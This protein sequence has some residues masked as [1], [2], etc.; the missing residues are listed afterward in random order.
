MPLADLVPILPSQFSAPLLTLQSAITQVEFYDDHLEIE[1]LTSNSRK[2]KGEFTAFG[3]ML[4]W[5][6]D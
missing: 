3:S 5:K 2:F 4:E 1:G 6:Q